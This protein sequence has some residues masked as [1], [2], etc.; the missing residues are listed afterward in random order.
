MIHQQIGATIINQTCCETE[1]NCY[2][3]LQ[4]VTR[5]VME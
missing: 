1:E 4:L 5:S 2:R 3:N